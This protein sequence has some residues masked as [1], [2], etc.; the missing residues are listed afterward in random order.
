MRNATPLNMTFALDND[1]TPLQSAAHLQVPGSTQQQQDP[2]PLPAAEN[3]QPS[4]QPDSEIT[5]PS[6]SANGD[7]THPSNELLNQVLSTMQK[8]QS[9][10]QKIQMNVTNLAANV[11][12]KHRAIEANINDTIEAT[13]S[14]RMADQEMRFSQQFLQLSGAAGI[15][16]MLAPVEAHTQQPSGTAQQPDII[17]QPQVDT[18]PIIDSLIS[19][20]ATTGINS[21]SSAAVVSPITKVIQR[22]AALHPPPL[23]IHQQASVAMQVL[24]SDSEQHQEQTIQQQTE[25][26]ISGR[27]STEP[28]LAANARK[29]DATP[30]PM[31]DS[32]LS[33]TELLAI[34]QV[35]KQNESE[36]CSQTDMLSNAI[37]PQVLEAL[38]KTGAAAS[39]APLNEYNTDEPFDAWLSKFEVRMAI[40]GVHN[41][42]AKAVLLQQLIGDKAYKFYATLPPDVKT[43]YE[44]LKPCLLARLKPTMPRASRFERA[45]MIT[46]KNDESVIDF[47]HRLVDEAQLTSLDGTNVEQLIAAIFKQ[48]LRPDIKNKITITTEVTLD[49]L[50]Q[51]ARTIEQ[52]NENRRAHQNSSNQHSVQPKQQRQSMPSQQHQYRPHIP[53]HTGAHQGQ[54]RPFVPNQIQSAAPQQPWQAPTT[55]PAQ[56]MYQAPRP[57]SANAANPNVICGTCGTRGHIQVNCPNRNRRSQSGMG[58]VD[59]ESIDT[60]AVQRQSKQLALQ[61][62]QMISQPEAT[63]ANAEP[64]QMQ[65]TPHLAYSV[66]NYGTEPPYLYYDCDQWLFPPHD[67]Y[68]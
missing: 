37:S 60:G 31:P 3:Q 52:Q 44:K 19:D 68:E 39:L 64:T 14:A 59:A 11:N 65:D 51:M 29:I 41:N 28:A 40:T 30:L 9:E 67:E 2:A 16:N 48:Q 66:D 7:A 12:Q 43:D 49:K 46:Q 53:V 38:R 4:A 56:R 22:H 35:L 58:T 50:L 34:R 61:P 5:N 36:Y 21:Q 17:T 1:G 15:E 8:M 26:T 32:S 24:T 57:Q 33:A 27:A 20:T 13:I 18:Q 55:A 23:G 62:E 10:M 25:T 54:P 45:Y 47:Y 42:T 6:A 63:N